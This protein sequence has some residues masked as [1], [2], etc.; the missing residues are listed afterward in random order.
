MNFLYSGGSCGDYRE[1]LSGDYYY[2][3]EGKD[4][5]IIRNNNS[6]MIPC[7]VIS[8]DY[9]EDFILVKQIQK[10]DCF[11]LVEF[12]SSISVGALNYWV[13]Q[14]KTDS[15]YGPLS[16]SEFKLLRKKLN[17]NPSLDINANED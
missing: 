15:L 7:D 4:N 17:V 13:I 12:D 1:D 2:V 5:S 14:V 9:D 6:H 3:Y 11:A 8:Y 16:F 10:S